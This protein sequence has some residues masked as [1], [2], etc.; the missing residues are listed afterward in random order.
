MHQHWKHWR[1]VFEYKT[2]T[3]RIHANPQCN[4]MPKEIKLE[5]NTAEF[6]DQDGYVC[7]EVKGAIHGLSQSEYVA[8]QDLI[9]NSS[10]ISWIPSS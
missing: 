8:N 1:H 10:Y 7:M 6:T 5:Y 2:T 3:T 4:L 9:K